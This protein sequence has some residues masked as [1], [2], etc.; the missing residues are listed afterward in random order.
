MLGKIWLSGSSLIGLLKFCRAI[1]R[2]WIQCSQI[3]F[4]NISPFEIYTFPGLPLD[5]N[6]LQDVTDYI[7]SPYVH[8]P[9]FYYDESP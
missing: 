1:D 8:T 3:D 2:R 4:S 5:S 6:K 9:I 7:S